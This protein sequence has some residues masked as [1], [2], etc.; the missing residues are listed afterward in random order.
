M[1]ALESTTH[2][3]ETVVVSFLLSVLC[4]ANV[5][6]LINTRTLTIVLQ[7][8]C[9]S[10]KPHH[11]PQRLVWEGLLVPWEKTMEE[12]TCHLVH[13][14]SLVL[15]IVYNMEFLCTTWNLNSIKRGAYNVEYLKEN[16]QSCHPF[17]VKNYHVKNVITFT[18]Y[19]TL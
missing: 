1:W 2:G 11:H 3:L 18:F 12:G 4:L 19:T 5:S 9:L 17:Q 8:I 13:I 7:N 15:R 16:V 6:N 14:A 10:A